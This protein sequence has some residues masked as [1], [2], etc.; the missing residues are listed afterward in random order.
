MA[1]TAASKGNGAAGKNNVYILYY[2]LALLHC[3]DYCQGEQALAEN[4]RAGALL[5]WIEG[6]CEKNINTR[7]SIMPDLAFNLIRARN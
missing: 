4:Q 5:T 3:G 1:D 7:N 6:H 2:L